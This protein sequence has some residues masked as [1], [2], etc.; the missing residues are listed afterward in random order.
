MLFKKYRYYFHIK[1]LLTI[2][3]LQSFH[4]FLLIS[5]NIL[6]P[7]SQDRQPR[8]NLNR[9]IKILCFPEDCSQFRG[10][11]YGSHR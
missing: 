1:Q 11:G 2:L 10:Q 8:N 4:S 3:D 7:E 9:G 6:N 5:V